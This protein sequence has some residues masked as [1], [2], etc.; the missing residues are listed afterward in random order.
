MRVY[1]FTGNLWAANDSEAGDG[2]REIH[3]WSKL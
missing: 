2:N 1:I 3:M